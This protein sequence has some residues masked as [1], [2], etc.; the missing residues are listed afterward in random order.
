MDP[1][2]FY[3][4]LVQLQDGNKH[5]K[6]AP[7]PFIAHA[8][9]LSRSGSSE[10]SIR[11]SLSKNSSL[12]RS[13]VSIR[14]STHFP[15]G[16]QDG[17]S[18]GNNHI[19]EKH[20]HNRQTYIKRLAYLNKSEVPVLALGSIFAAMHGALFPI[21]G[22]LI[23]SVFKMFFEPPHQLRRGSRFWALM[24]CLLG[25]IALLVV[26][27]QYYLFG[28]AGAKLIQRI[29]SLSFEKMVHQEI[30]WFDEPSNSRLVWILILYLDVGSI[31]SAQNNFYDSNKYFQVYFFQWTTR[32]EVSNRC[33]D[34]AQACWRHFGCYGSDCRNNYCGT[35]D[36]TGVKLEIGTNNTCTSTFTGPTRIFSTEVPSWF[37]WRC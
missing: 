32:C 18:T 37:Q 2:S 34:R 17:S 14:T 1:Q 7:S 4:Q 31:S 15:V 23:S 20:N 29:R 21:F 35:R 28:V 5:A 36:S 27:A 13:N 16:S 9:K 3:F 11:R 19:K 30:G 24:Y 10:L 25:L 12:G 8:K 26:P 33:F 22:I 6:E